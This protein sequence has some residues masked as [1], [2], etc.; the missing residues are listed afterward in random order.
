MRPPRARQEKLSRRAA[1]SVHFANA[2]ILFE[3]ANR[4]R[5]PSPRP[6]RL[7]RIP[8]LS[9]RASACSIASPSSMS[10]RTRS[11]P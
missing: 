10:R 3:R 4:L 8:T 6:W 11:L 1:S 7:L 5:Q 9:P 2:R